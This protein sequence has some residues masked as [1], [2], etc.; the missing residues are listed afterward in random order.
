MDRRKISG[1]LVA[2][3]LFWILVSPPL[4]AEEE[5]PERNPLSGD[6][7]AIASGKSWFRGVCALCHGPKADGAGERGNGADLRKFN[8]GFRRYIETVRNGRQIAGRSQNMP[9][10]KGVLDDK[11]I[12]EIGAYLETLAMEGADWQGGLKTD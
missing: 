2:V 7:K 3:L 5:V 12:M 6:A 11:Q 8:K 1:R 9:A 10:W 4:L